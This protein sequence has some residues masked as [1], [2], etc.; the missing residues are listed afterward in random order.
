MMI[1]R[2]ESSGIDSPPSVLTDT[3]RPAPDRE[4]GPR[5]KTRTPPGESCLHCSGF[6][7]LSDM[8]SLESGDRNTDGAVALHQLR[9][10]FG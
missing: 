4:K 9:R 6:V 2:A 1:L 7:S 8:A 5:N 10:L 3:F